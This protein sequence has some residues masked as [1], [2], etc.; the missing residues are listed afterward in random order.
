M[1]RLPHPTAGLLAMEAYVPVDGSIAADL[2]GLGLPVGDM[3]ATDRAIQSFL[4]MRGSA[5]FDQVPVAA[6]HELVAMFDRR[7]LSIT[8]ANTSDPS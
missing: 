5:G 4:S 6:Y 8:S 7:W 1:I 2:A 3:A